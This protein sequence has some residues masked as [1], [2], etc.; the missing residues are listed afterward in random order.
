MKGIKAHVNE[1][2]VRF[3][4]FIQWPGVLKKMGNDTNRIIFTGRRGG[5]NQGVFG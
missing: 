2:G 4:F 1:G 3:P 5:T